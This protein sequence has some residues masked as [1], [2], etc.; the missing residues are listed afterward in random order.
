MRDLNVVDYDY[1]LQHETGAING[2]DEEGYEHT[3]IILVATRGTI[4]SRSQKIFDFN[5]IHPNIKKI[6]NE[7]ALSAFVDYTMKE[8]FQELD[9]PNT[10]DSRKL[11]INSII[12]IEKFT[13]RCKSNTRGD[14][15]F[16]SQGI[17]LIDTIQRCNTKTK[18]FS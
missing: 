4:V 8:W 2:D 3:H 1:I 7:K 10:S 9:D 18:L 12:K 6:K 11:F 14:G 16:S 13:S 15:H 17:N 5:D